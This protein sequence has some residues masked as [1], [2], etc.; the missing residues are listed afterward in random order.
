MPLSSHMTPQNRADKQFKYI[1]NIIS[2]V[3][4]K[5]CRQG[6]TSAALRSRK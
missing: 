4:A 1:Q 2:A 3:E 6:F 5:T